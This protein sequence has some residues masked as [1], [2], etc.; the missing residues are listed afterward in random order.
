VPPE[1]T[2]FQP[3]FFALDVTLPFVDLHQEADWG[4]LVANAAGETLWGGRALRWL[5]W[6]NIMFGWIASL[7]FV[8]IVS[9]LVEKD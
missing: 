4:P 9:R 5:M 3:F 7:M 6:F 1:Y 8:A 2:T